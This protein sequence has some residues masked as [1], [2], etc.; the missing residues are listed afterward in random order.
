VR[1]ADLADL[2]GLRYVGAVVPN[3]VVARY[4]DVLG[5][6]VGADRLAEMTACKTRRDGP[7]SYHVTAVSPPQL[8]NEVAEARAG[9]CSA[10]TR[11]P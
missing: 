11:C 1:L 5:R 3:T 8:R 10:P 9:S 2:D 4:L 7:D 6:H